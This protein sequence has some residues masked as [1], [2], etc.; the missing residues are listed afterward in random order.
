L[1]AGKGLRQFSKTRK[2]ET[3]TET[4]TALGFSTYFSKGA[5]MIQNKFPL[6]LHATGQYCKKIRG[7]LFYFGKDA[8]VA[9]ERYLD[10]RDYL[11]AGRV[12]PSMGEAT[13]G[14]ALDQFLSA[15][16]L[17]EQTGEIGER[18]YRDYEQTCERIAKLGTMRP[19]SSFDET[20]MQRLR[21]LLAR[22]K[23]GPI[24][25]TTLR[26]ELTRARM[27]FLYINDYLV[28]KRIPYRKE[29]RSPNR[30]EFR[31]LANERGPRMFDAKQI[32]YIKKRSPSVFRLQF[33]SM[34]GVMPVR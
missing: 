31:K 11:L 25:P 30:R 27:V 3:T 20:D 16:K 23:N 22:G 9:L 4:T 17:A 29:L 7:R 32:R 13:L 28:T 21:K 18:S 19:L 6:T 2:T 1:F 26:N 15:K 14:I 8:D 34:S 5:S 24:G 12:P 33:V 10:Q